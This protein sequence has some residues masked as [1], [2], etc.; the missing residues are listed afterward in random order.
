MSTVNSSTKR[1]MFRS[2]RIRSRS[3]K[4]SSEKRETDITVVAISEMVAEALKASKNLE[5]EGISIEIIDLRTIKP[6]DEEIIINSLK[7][8]GRLLIADTGWT[9]GGVS[10][11]IAARIGEKAFGLLKAP[12]VRVASE[13]VPDAGKLRPGEGIL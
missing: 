8:T 5:A 1:D 9:T 11:E 12:I 7:K 2:R 3:E 6:F 13:D 10:A 4:A